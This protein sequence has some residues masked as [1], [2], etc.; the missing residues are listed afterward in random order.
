MANSWIPNT[1]MCHST[2]MVAGAFLRCV[3]NFFE[4]QIYFMK[5]NFEVSNS[6]KKF[7]HQNYLKLQILINKV[8]LHFEEKFHQSQKKLQPL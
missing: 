7:G 3:K 8:N 4:V 5:F 1:W 2:A 6:W